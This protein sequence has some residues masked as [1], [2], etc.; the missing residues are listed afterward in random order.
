MQIRKL[1]VFRL[2]PH[3]LGAD[4]LTPPPPVPI[5][6]VSCS[7]FGAKPLPEPML[8][9][10][11]LKTNFSEIWI[12]ILPFCPGE[13]SQCVDQEGGPDRGEDSLWECQFF[14]KRAVYTPLTSCPDGFY[15]SYLSECYW[16]EHPVINPSRLKCSPDISSANFNNGVSRAQCYSNWLII[17]ATS[18]KTCRG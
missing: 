15:P 13:M 18:N 10:C 2:S 16:Y 5:I 14:S 4:D 7:L 17:I 8:A 11:Q 9:Y 1:H 6:C 3:I 12:R